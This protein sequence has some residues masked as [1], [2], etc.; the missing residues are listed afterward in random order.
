VTLGCGFPC[1]WQLI[2][3][4]VVFEKYIKFIG[5]TIKLGGSIGL[6]CHIANTISVIIEKY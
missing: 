3:V 4:P 2:I 5:S 6:I 1:P